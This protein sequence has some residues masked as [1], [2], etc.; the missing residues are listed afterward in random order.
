M[1]F[2][3]EINNTMSFTS[4]SS[5]GTNEWIMDG[6]TLT[7]EGGEAV[8]EYEL[9]RI[10]SLVAQ[11]ETFVTVTNLFTGESDSNTHDD[12][13]SETGTLSVPAEAGDSIEI[14]LD[15]DGGSNEVSGVPDSIEQTIEEEQRFDPDPD[16]IDVFCDLPDEEVYTED[17]VGVIIDVENSDTVVAWVE[18][19]VSVGSEVVGLEG[20]VADESVQEWE[21]E[22]DADALGVGDHDVLVDVLEIGEARV[23]THV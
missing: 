10:G 14:E 2:C 1:C 17:V 15:A 21:V 6:I 4:M 7:K 23:T 3:M 16:L 12:Y 13:F 11:A 22:I 8:V 5:S 19:E 9:E 18:I 20:N